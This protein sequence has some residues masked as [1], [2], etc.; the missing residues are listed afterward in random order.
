MYS[1]VDKLPAR[2]FGDFLHAAL[3]VTGISF[4]KPRPIKGNN[5]TG[6]FMKLNELELNLDAIDTGVWVDDPA[7]D[8]GFAVRVK[9]RRCNGYQKGQTAALTKAR[10][11]SRKRDIEISVIQKIDNEQVAKHCLLDWK[12]FFDDNGQPIPYSAELAQKLM[13][14]R[15]YQPFQDFV[16]SAIDRVDEN[17]LEDVEDIQKNSQPS[18]TI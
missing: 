5:Q 2:R 14:D 18:S 17:D 1:I 11:T 3:F 8:D 10:K 9:G 6:N 16:K 7:D 15:K 13:T 12:N 4:F